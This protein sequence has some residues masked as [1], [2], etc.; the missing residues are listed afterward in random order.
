MTSVAGFAPSWRIVPLGAV[1]RM[2]QVV[3]V[4][5]AVVV[6]VGVT[7][8]FASTG[9]VLAIPSMDQAVVRP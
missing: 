3:L 6:V 4:P 9:N 5:A 2:C 8:S 7:C 1:T